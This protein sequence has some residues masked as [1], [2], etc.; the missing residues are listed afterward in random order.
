[1]VIREIRGN[2]G[3]D[4]SVGR[5]EKN[6]KS[7]RSLPRARTFNREILKRVISIAH[8]PPRLLVCRRTIRRHPFST[9]FRK[10]F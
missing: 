1:M 4:R 3:R 6:N 10:L 2:N 8:R 7:T 5:D 9:V